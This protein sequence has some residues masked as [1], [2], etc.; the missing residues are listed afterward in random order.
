MKIKFLRL[1]ITAV[2]LLSFPI[3]NFGQA[4][5]L[6]KASSFALFTAAGAFTSNGAITVTGDIGNYT[7]AVNS[8]PATLN[9][10]KHFGDSTAFYA[11]ADVST[12]YA[13][14]KAETCGGVLGTT[15]GSGQTVNPG[16]YCTGAATTLG[17][18]L[19]LDAGGDAN[20]IFVFQIDGAFTSGSQSKVVLKNSASACNVYW[21]INGAVALGDSSVFLGTIIADGAIITGATTVLN[22]RGL[23][24]AGAI[25]L[26]ASTVTLGCSSSSSSTV[27]TTQP[28]SQT[29]C[30]GSSTSFSV[31]ATGTGL[32][33]QWRNGSTNI[34]NGTHISGATTATLTINPVATTDAANNYNVII[35]STAAANDTSSNASLIVNSVTAATVA[36]QTVCSGTNAVFAVSAT[37]TGPATI[38][39]QWQLSANGGT[40]FS[41]ISGATAASYTVTAPAGTLDNNQYRALVS[42]GSCTSFTSTS[43]TLR[44]NGVSA[45]TVA[46][47]TVCSGANAVFT[48]SPTYSGPT[49]LTYQW[50]IS[51]NG[52]TSFSNISGAT[53]S[54]YT[55]TAP[56]GSSDNYQYETVVTSKIGRAHV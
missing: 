4:P 50:M 19:T 37:S 53:A 35:S 28:G 20:A 14:L 12:A 45:A 54:S 52:G 15:M 3:M 31:S 11:A 7:G 29:A 43:G 17:G 41:N 34:S 23:S 24:T 26:N 8:T 30:A 51:T 25:T 32:T 40:S 2:A 55:V 39:Y 16:I 38:S 21:Q 10:N 18:T 44:V 33:Y 5:N 1:F 56:G 22:G 36:S 6:G 42:S 49:G 47:Q 48:V 9:G 13:Y 27:I 46:G